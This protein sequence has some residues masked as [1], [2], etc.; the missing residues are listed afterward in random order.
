MGRQWGNER[1]ESSQRAKIVD[2]RAEIRFI[3]VPR[4]PVRFRGAPPGSAV[5]RCAHMAIVALIARRFR[6]V[7]WLS[8]VP[9]SPF[10][11][12]PY[13]AL[14]TNTMRF[15]TTAKLVLSEGRAEEENEGGRKRSNARKGGF[16]AVAPSFWCSVR[17]RGC[18]FCVSTHCPSP[19][20]L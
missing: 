1:S 12:F 15:E 9:I 6:G 2:F 4:G 20:L 11:S 17:F 16:V 19:A 3:G 13:S 14:P 8:I 18:P 7:P 10:S 5:V